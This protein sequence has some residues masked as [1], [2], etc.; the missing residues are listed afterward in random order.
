MRLQFTLFVSLDTAGPGAQSRSNADMLSLKK[1]FDSETRWYSY[2]IS[3][4]ITISIYTLYFAILFPLYVKLLI[5]LVHHFS[6]NQ[7]KKCIHF[8][9]I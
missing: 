5:L 4:R 3:T 2:V 6:W 1:R 9:I 7:N 8:K